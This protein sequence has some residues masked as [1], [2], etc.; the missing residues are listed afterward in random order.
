MNA[1]EFVKVTKRLR[2]DFI[3]KLKEGAPGSRVN[4]DLGSGVDSW[5]DFVEK[6]CTHDWKLKDKTSIHGRFCCKNC[7]VFAT[8]HFEGVVIEDKESLSK[9]TTSAGI[10]DKFPSFAP[11]TQLSLF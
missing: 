6:E 1:R 7:Q 11:Q 2:D 8:T 5:L 9:E 3:K 10:W 4:I